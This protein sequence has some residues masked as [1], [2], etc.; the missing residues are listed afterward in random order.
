MRFRDWLILALVLVALYCSQGLAWGVTL[1]VDGQAATCANYDPLPPDGTTG[2][3][4]PGSSQNYSEPRAAAAA[5]LCGDVIELVRT[6]VRPGAVSGTN[7]PQPPGGGAPVCKSID[8]KWDHETDGV[9]TERSYVEFIGKVCTAGTRIVMRTYDN[10]SYGPIIIT[11][12]G[13]EDGDYGG[14]PG[15]ADGVFGQTNERLIHLAGS[16]FITIEGPNL[17]VE[18]SNAWGISVVGNNNIVREVITENNWGANGEPLHAQG[19]FNVIEDSESRYTRHRTGIRLSA[20]SNDSTIQR[21]YSWRSGM[22]E[23]CSDPARTIP[24]PPGVSPPWTHCKVLPIPGDDSGGG[25]A[26]GIGNGKECHDGQPVDTNLCNRNKFV[27]NVSYNNADGGHDYSAA[28]FLSRG[29]Y[30][31]ADG[32]NGVG[33]VGFKILREV[34]IGDYTYVENIAYCNRQGRGY[35]P[36]RDPTNSNPYRMLNNT[37]VANNPTGL[38]LNHGFVPGGAANNN[39]TNNVGSVHSPADD[40]N[41]DPVTQGTS[42]SNWAANNLKPQQFSGD[43]AFVNPQ[44]WQATL[45]DCT[46]VAFTIPVAD[47]DIPGRVQWLRDQIEAAFRPDVGSGLIGNGTPTSYVDPQTLQTVTVCPA[48]CDI[49]AIQTTTVSSSPSIFRNGDLRNGSPR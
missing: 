29:N 41:V 26:D 5:S 37:S 20:P 22:E 47:T 36:R 46:T 17:Y 14:T 21:S 25:N 8:G 24:T 34:Y 45:N 1:Y 28:A 4:G 31:I 35:E 15:D 10:G 11:G 3:C 12:R 19:N 30:S 42:L 43:P 38:G 16:D 27:G 2:T 7:C 39:W 44:L 23:V 48:P 18:Y 32:W 33:G 49:G 6:P 13:F 40:I 9:S